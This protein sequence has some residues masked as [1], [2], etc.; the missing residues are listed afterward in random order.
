MKKRKK[1]KKKRKK[2]QHGSC[3]VSSAWEFP[4]A[5]VLG[6]QS[7]T[8][9]LLR[10]VQYSGRRETR[11]KKQESEREREGTFACWVVAHHSSHPLHGLGLLLQAELSQAVGQTG[12]VL[13]LRGQPSSSQ[14][15]ACGLAVRASIGA[16]VSHHAHLRRSRGVEM[17]LW[18]GTK[19]KKKNS[20]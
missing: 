10:A 15:L 9:A 8:T 5:N 2:Y 13:E 14:T 3:R 11:N 16:R 6:T 20:S 1:E 7:T 19:K 4:A 12:F 17:E 18:R